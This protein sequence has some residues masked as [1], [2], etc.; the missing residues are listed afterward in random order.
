MFKKADGSVSVMKIASAVIAFVAFL[1]LLSSFSSVETGSQGIV[2]R[3]GKVERSLEPGLHFVSPIDSL[4]Q[5]DVQIQK[6]QA[7]ATAAS[8][9]QQNVSATVAVNYRVDS[10]KVVDLYKNIGTDYKSRVIDP[11]IQEVVKAV[12]AKYTANDLLAKRPQVSDEIRQG[13]I[14]RL[15]PYYLLISDVSVVNFQYS[16][17]YSDAIESKVTAEQNSLAAKNKL[18]QANYE[19]QAIKITSE[20]AN[21]EKYIQLQQLKVQDKIADKWNGIG[22]QNNCYGTALTNP[23][24]VLN[25][26]K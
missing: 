11:A 10:A 14:E 19:A 26:N 22:C 23:L 1:M 17:V 25:L 18:E 20:A 21:N 12:T 7:E 6:E 2:T 13:L 9:D 3:F 24:P 8:V 5:I 4:H 16:K 15:T